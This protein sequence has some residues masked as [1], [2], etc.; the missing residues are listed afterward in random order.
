VLRGVWGFTEKAAIIKEKFRGGQRRKA[1]IKKILHATQP[2]TLGKV[3]TK[4]EDKNDAALVQKQNSSIGHVKGG[5]NIGSLERE[6]RKQR[7][8]VNS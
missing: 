4:E 7:S 8:E 3:K 1:Y 2:R 5:P 6:K